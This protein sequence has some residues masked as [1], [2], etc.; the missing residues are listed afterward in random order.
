MRYYARFHAR[1][2]Y[3]SI[4]ATKPPCRCEVPWAPVAPPRRRRCSQGSCSR[5]AGWPRT[6]SPLCRRR[7]RVYGLQF[8]IYTFVYMW[9]GKRCTGRGKYGMVYMGYIWY[10]VHGRGIQPAHRQKGLPDQSN[11][12]LLG[13][14]GVE[15]I[16]ELAAGLELQRGRKRGCLGGK[17]KALTS[18]IMRVEKN[19]VHRDGGG[20]GTLC[21]SGSR[22][23]ARVPCDDRRVF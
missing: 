18:E 1:R 19:V 15:F 17:I 9:G 23:Y 12:H 2:L 10:M 16:P 14:D 4:C 13:I 7:E 11:S 5:T 21:V 20:M 8:H 22:G 6:R 3:K